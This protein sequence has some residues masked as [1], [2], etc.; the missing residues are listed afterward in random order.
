MNTTL[1]D[2]NYF[3]A[4]NMSKYSLSIVFTLCLKIMASASR[5]H[6]NYWRYLRKE[7]L[8]NT[9]GCCFFLL[10]ISFQHV[11]ETSQGDGFALR[12]FF[13]APKTYV[14][15]DSYLNMS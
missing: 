2:K 8:M 14:L 10:N 7:I 13:K 1:Y 3:L 12:R 15:V 9:K 4:L 11:K 6:K 5:K